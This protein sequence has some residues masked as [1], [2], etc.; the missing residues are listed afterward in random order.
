[1]L[2]SNPRRPTEYLENNM[3]P[4]PHKELI[5]L[6]P[7]FRYNLVTDFDVDVWVWKEWFLKRNFKNVNPPKWFSEMAPYN[8]I[9]KYDWDEAEFID[10]E[11]KHEDLF[12]LSFFKNKIL[13]Q[14][15][16]LAIISDNKPTTYA[17][18]DFLK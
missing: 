13:A 5:K 7:E 1:V 11:E 9:V 16:L 14:K 10:G 12:Q 2:G 6:Y 15:L 18:S 4:M 8:H 17:N 3:K